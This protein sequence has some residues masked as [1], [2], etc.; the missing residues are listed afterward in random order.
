MITRFSLVWTS[1]RILVLF[2]LSLQKHKKIH[3]KKTSNIVWNFVA[4]TQ[5][6]GT[7]ITVSTKGNKNVTCAPVSISKPKCTTDICSLYCVN[8]SDRGLCTVLS[9]HMLVVKKL[10]FCTSL[11]P[12]WFWFCLDER[13]RTIQNRSHTLMTLSFL[14]PFQSS[15][16]SRHNSSP[17]SWSE[18][19][20]HG[21]APTPNWA[22]SYETTAQRTTPKQLLC[23]NF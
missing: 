4:G 2:G 23:I 18:Q 1:C 19:T 9:Q 12:A 22:T 10:S 21:V 17:M 11:Q 7:A 3:K 6:Q 5:T 15:H 13:V 20:A 8:K 14:S 16:L